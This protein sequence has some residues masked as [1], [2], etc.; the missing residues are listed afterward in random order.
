MLLL[1][2]VVFYLVI[3]EV[4]NRGVVVDF[5]FFL[6]WKRRG[7]FLNVCDCFDSF[8][9]FSKKFVFR[10]SYGSVFE[11]NSGFLEI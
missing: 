2:V 7:V 3:D 10:V 4:G 8:F 6:G 5:I 1:V 9:L 11:R